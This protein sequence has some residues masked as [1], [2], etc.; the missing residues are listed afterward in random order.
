MRH[1]WGI[2]ER[3][4]LQNAAK[5]RGGFWFVLKVD[6]SVR[7]MFPKHRGVSS[8]LREDIPRLQTIS[9]TILWQIIHYI[10]RVQVRW[11]VPTVGNY[12]QLVRASGPGH[13]KI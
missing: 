9:W 13:G 3:F 1:I 12:Q 7:K 4:V 10:F 8:G 5:T 11:L 6:Q 2:L